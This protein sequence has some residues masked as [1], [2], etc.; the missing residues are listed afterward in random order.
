MGG[1]WPREVPPPL[2]LVADLPVPQAPVNTPV[3]GLHHDWDLFAVETSGQ[4][5]IQQL[6]ANPFFAN[7]SAN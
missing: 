5:S 2:P 4:L 1:G 7:L 3:G 6:Q